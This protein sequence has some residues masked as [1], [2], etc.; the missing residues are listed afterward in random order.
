MHSNDKLNILTVKYVIIL[1]T[2]GI[3]VSFFLMN[4]T[5]SNIFEEYQLAQKEDNIT[6]VVLIKDE[7]KNTTLIET[8]TGKKISL[9][10]YRFSIEREPL[11]DYLEQGDSIYRMSSSDTLYLH[12][13]NGKVIEFDVP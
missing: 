2:L 6:E 8:I 9:R 3:P 13:T 1:I 7:Y 11:F 4:R 10:A 5:T 12:K